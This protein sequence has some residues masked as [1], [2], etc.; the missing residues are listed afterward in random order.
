[1]CI[2]C[3]ENVQHSIPLKHDAKNKNLEGACKT[4]KPATRKAANIYHGR[5]LRTAVR[6]EAGLF[7]GSFLRKGKVFALNQAY[8]KP[9]G[10]EGRTIPVSASGSSNNQEDLKDA[11][12]F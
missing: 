11:P 12:G 9:E 4:G 10:P 7:C 6:K 2:L 1:M 5:C 3:R 8:L